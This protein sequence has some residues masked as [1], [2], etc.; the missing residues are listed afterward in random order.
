MRM[1]GALCGRAGLLLLWI[2][3]CLPAHEAAESTIAP[4]S[5]GSG[6]SFGCT[7]EAYLTETNVPGF[8]GA[9]VT[10]VYVESSLACGDIPETAEFQAQH[11]DNKFRDDIMAYLSDS[12][13]SSAVHGGKD[14]LKDKVVYFEQP[15]CGPGDQSK[16]GGDFVASFYALYLTM[17][18]AKAAG[19]VG[20]VMALPLEGQMSSTYSICE[21]AGANWCLPSCTMT[22]A[23]AASLRSAVGWSQGHLVHFDTRKL[24]LNVLKPEVPDPLYTAVRTSARDRFGYPFPAV[25]AL[26]NPEAHPEVT[27]PAAVARFQDKCTFTRLDKVDGGYKDYTQDVDCRACWAMPGGPLKNPGELRGKVVLFAHPTDRS[28][29]DRHELV[30]EYADTYSLCHPWFY[31][32]A[33][34]AQDAGAV[35]ALFDTGDPTLGDTPGPS[36]VGINISIPSL[37]LI[38]SDAQK[39]R[40]AV[41]ASLGLNVTLPMLEAGAGT[42]PYYAMNMQYSSTIHLVWHPPTAEVR[43]GC[44][45]T[46]G[47]QTTCPIGACCCYA[48]QS[49]FGPR[50]SYPGL[51][52]ATAV[53]ARASPACYDSDRC[54]EC[55][56]HVGSWNVSAGLT[57]F[58][59]LGDLNGRVAIMEEVEFACFF[60]YHQFVEAAE[61]AGATMAVVVG[62]TDAVYLM[63]DLHDSSPNTTDALDYEPTIP[64]YNVN[65]QCYRALGSAF[66]G[67]FE[68]DVPQRD[69]NGVSID[70]LASPGNEWSKDYAEVFTSVQI[71]GPPAKIAGAYLAGQSEFNP[72]SHPSVTAALAVA[73][74]HPSCGNLNACGE[75]EQQTS[76]FLTDSAQGL[77]ADWSGRIVMVHLEDILC[78]ALSSALKAVQVAG[79]KGALITNKDDAV[80]TFV[81]PDIGFVVTIPS[82]NLQ[83]TDGM[84]LESYVLAAADACEADATQCVRAKLPAI[85]RGRADPNVEPFVQDANPELAKLKEDFKEQLAADEARAAARQDEA[86][87]LLSGWIIALVVVVG[88]AGLCGVVYTLYEKRRYQRRM[89]AYNQRDAGQQAGL[90]DDEDAQD[91]G[92]G[93]GEYGEYAADEED[94][95]AT[96]RG[97]GTGPGPNPLRSQRDRHVLLWE[98]S[99]YSEEGAV[100]MSNR[101]VEDPGDPS[102]LALS[103]A[104]AMTVANI[105]EPAEYLPPPLPPHASL[106]TPSSDEGD[107]AAAAPRQG[108]GSIGP[109]GSIVEMSHSVGTPEQTMSGG[110]R[111]S[112]QELSDVGLL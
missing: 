86:P 6:Q 50:T 106:S 28:A 26:F 110:A 51:T 79:A 72:L 109:E 23:E 57:P 38:P 105:D 91:R 83:R 59:N 93:G 13:L 75:C 12:M 81:P 95:G 112:D 2:A 7:P 100:A 103:P 62:L 80:Y 90:M 56:L 66:S 77:S 70:A 42:T 64:S 67:T 74:V 5:S 102:R 99:V 97:V 1:G 20:V 49:E 11:P 84:F 40:D 52:N 61:A 65:K 88:L 108:G 45:S 43:A 69:A 78:V 18:G 96:T 31:M 46:G 63:P 15:A 111:V 92:V 16:S 101:F 21:Y 35:G 30:T 14:A 27:A 4:L 98:G 3:T 36:H 89:S 32:M 19:A 55:P 48:G 33:R 107:N 73:K 71:L 87:R 24:L 54:L 82:F 39:I 37:G 29:V 47:A 76:I 104:V 44:D 25:P 34:I 58:S 53:V 41:E 9:D 17:V 68:H 10:F 85:I 8:H 94:P 22:K 60:T